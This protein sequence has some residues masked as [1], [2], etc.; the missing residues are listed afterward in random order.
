MYIIRE[1]LPILSKR[2]DPNRFEINPHLDTTC[3]HCKKKISDIPAP[4]REVTYQTL[5]DRW[6]LNNS[7]PGR[8]SY[9]SIPTGDGNIAKL[10]SQCVFYRGVID[11]INEFVMFVFLYMSRPAWGHCMRP[12]QSFRGQFPPTW[13]PWWRLRP[14][15]RQV[16]F[17]HWLVAEKID[18]L[19]MRKIPQIVRAKSASFMCQFIRQSFPSLRTKYVFQLTLP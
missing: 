17:F 6:Y 12:G 18:E 3:I 10:F 14:C 5:P 7:R 1:I 2:G 11:A 15:N 8:V 13:R 4:S 9:T 16:P 19:V